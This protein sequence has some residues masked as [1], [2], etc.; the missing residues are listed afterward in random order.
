M[1]VLGYLFSKN[2][3]LRHRVLENKEEIED[4]MEWMGIK[5]AFLIK[6]KNVIL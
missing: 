5:T 2:T 3:M 6:Q 4:L 1:F